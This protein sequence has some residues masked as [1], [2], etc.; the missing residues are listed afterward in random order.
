[1]TVRFEQHSLG[2]SY[3]QN[4]TRKGDGRTRQITLQ[5][6]KLTVNFGVVGAAVEEDAGSAR[7]TVADYVVEDLHVVTSLG[8]NDTWR[9][10]L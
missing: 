2:R 4:R 9:P 1:M 3:V 7:A 8:G 10:P 6:A 5:P